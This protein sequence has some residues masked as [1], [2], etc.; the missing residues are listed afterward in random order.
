MTSSKNDQ[1]EREAMSLMA[2]QVA[3]G[4]R[5]LGLHIKQHDDIT[6]RSPR[7]GPGGYLGGKEAA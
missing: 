7:M 3:E 6:R 1:T 5:T 2:R 4:S